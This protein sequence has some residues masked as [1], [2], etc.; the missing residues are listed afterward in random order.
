MEKQTY[1]RTMASCDKENAKVLSNSI[2]WRSCGFEVGMDE[3]TD[4]MITIYLPLFR[5]GVIM[6]TFLYHIKMYK[7]KMEDARVDNQSLGFHLLKTT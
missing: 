1:M 4:K 5:R 7:M 6:I 3:R 2:Q